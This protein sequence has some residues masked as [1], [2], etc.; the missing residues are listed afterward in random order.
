MSGSY[1]EARPELLPLLREFAK[2]ELGSFPMEKSLEFVQA[3]LLYLTFKPSKCFFVSTTCNANELVFQF[4]LEA[5]IWTVGLDFSFFFSFLLLRT[6]HSQLD[7]NR[8]CSSNGARS[9]SSSR[10]PYQNRYR[11]SLENKK[12]MYLLLEITVDGADSVLI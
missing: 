10:S 5:T 8:T 6:F 1:Y 4:Q 2:N 3:Q 12:R 11:A 9:E 7:S